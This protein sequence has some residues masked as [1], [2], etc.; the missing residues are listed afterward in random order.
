MKLVTSDMKP[1]T[2]KDVINNC[3]F[4]QNVGKV[5]YLFAYDRYMIKY[6]RSFV[7]TLCSWDK[8]DIFNCS[9]LTCLTDI[10]QDMFFE[11]IKKEYPELML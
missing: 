11:K 6:E 5:V 9:F 2:I 1:I 10:E 3:V 8:K 7:S 4:I